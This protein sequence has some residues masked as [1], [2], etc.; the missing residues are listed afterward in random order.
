MVP[1]CGNKNKKV[2]T[3]PKPQFKDNHEIA[4]EELQTSRDANFDALRK[5]LNALTK[6]LLNQ[7]LHNRVEESDL[8]DEFENPFARP[9]HQQ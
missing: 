1:I 5:E 6:A 8:E 7:Q 4:H 3:K 9:N 2:I